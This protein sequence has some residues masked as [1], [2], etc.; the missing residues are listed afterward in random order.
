MSDEQTSAVKLGDPELDK[1]VA[2][3]SER[4]EAALMHELSQGASFI[5]DKV[6][7]LAAAG[8]KRFRPMFA[9]LAS[10]FGPHPGSDEV[11]QA[12]V[13]VELTHLAT[14]YHDDVMDEADRRRGAE[15][16]NHRWNN[17]IAILAGDFVFSVASR[18]MAPL[19]A[20]TVQHFA[21]TF[22]ELV[23]GQMRETIGCPEG[24]DAIEHYL[25]VIRE[26]TAVLIRSAGFLG[27]VHSGADDAITESLANLGEH[28]GMI[29][30]IVDDLIDIF[31]DPSQSGKTP[32]TDLREGVF[33]LPTLYALRDETNVGEQL[34]E[35]L[36]KES[37]NDDEIAQAVDLIG[38]TDAREKCQHHIDEHRQRA[39]AELDSLPDDTAG[40]ALRTLVDYT[41]HRLG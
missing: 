2:A 29:F 21:D 26:K 16:A 24:E 23:T 28:I 13:A 14:L 6:T 22:G 1:F 7:H 40:D 41:I 5:T 32:G 9:L 10:R 31:S 36:A 15:S 37:L 39:F 38:R 11:I 17:S 19:G 8:G 4:C 12:A 33:T 30:Q 27:A 25:D 20:E 3:G 34:R 35:L 18:V